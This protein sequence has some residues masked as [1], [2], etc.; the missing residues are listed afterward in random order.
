LGI[1]F[2][3]LAF[4]EQFGNRFKNIAAVYGKVPLFYFIVHFYLIHLI[5]LVVLLM[6]GFSWSQLEFGSNTFG[7]PKGVESGLHLWAIYLI[8][9]GLVVL[10]YKPCHW[11]GKYKSTHTYWWLRYL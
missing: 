9:A 5:T 11:F 4:S 1:M 7:R 2:L 8:W 10:L 6:Q 3:L